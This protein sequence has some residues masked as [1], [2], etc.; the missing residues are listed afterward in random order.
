MCLRATCGQ[1]VGV[2]FAAAIGAAQAQDLVDKLLDNSE[3]LQTTVTLDRSVYFPGEAAIITITVANPTANALQV[4]APFTMRTGCLQLYTPALPGSTDPICNS[5]VDG[6]TPTT[7][8]QPGEQ[9]KI[10]LHSYDLQFDRGLPAMGAG[11][12]PRQ[13]GSF[14]LAYGYWNAKPVPFQVVLPRLEAAA[15][16]QVADITE[17]DETGKQVQFPGFMHVFAVEWEG[18]TFICV[19][20]DASRMNSVIVDANGNLED[21]PEVL[22]RIASS[23]TPVASLSATADAG[24]LTILW[25]DSEGNRQT[26]KYSGQPM[27]ASTAVGITTVP[28]GLSVSVD[29]VAY[30]TPHTF[31]WAPGTR[32]ALATGM[33]ETDSA[34]R[35]YAWTDWS[36]GL[37]TAHEIFAPV[38]TTTYTANFT[39]QYRL[40]TAVSPA[41]SGYITPMETAFSPGESQGLYAP[42]SAVKLSASPVSGY[43]FS[44]WTG[45]VA[46]TASAQ[47]S[48]VMN[49]AQAVTANFVANVA[50]P[51][52]SPGGGT[53][54]TPPLVA[55]TTPTRGASIR[56]TTDGSAPGVDSGTLYSGPFT[57][58]T[59][60]TI[61]A[62]A[63]A[64]G[65]ADSDV[66]S[67]TIGIEPL[68]GAPLFSPA[69][70]Q[71]P[72]AQTVTLRCPT[73][74]ASINYTLDG[75]IPSPSVGTLYAGPFTVSVT[76][77]VKAVA[78]GPGMAHSGVNSATYTIQPVAVL[79]L[80]AVTQALDATSRLMLPCYGLAFVEVRPH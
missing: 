13:A 14:A 41:H 53:Y 1:I 52:I 68:A 19:T 15:M 45:P 35:Q 70:G 32:Y 47:T 4:L 20:R 26:A 37:K 56:F 3:Q 11:S 34:G 29:G 58:K 78:Y 5:E 22:T 75:S 33:A 18:Q 49:G 21:A 10:T 46:N 38:D 28:S 2:C 79:D 57:V 64:S 25:E 67:A 50:A 76:T 55:I 62:I 48:V 16:V 6:S 73:P 43:T 60:S 40:T 71:Y 77:T 36:D 63:Y 9:R 54:I 65:M 69:A 23:A 39:M 44:G 72:V 51:L 66:A 12:V 7:E 80:P 17:T 24:T 59:T 31:Q 74:G 61:N 30:I 8:L 27:P 42:E